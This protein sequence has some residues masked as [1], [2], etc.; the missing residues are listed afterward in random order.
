[1]APKNT[2]L[3]HQQQHQQDIRIWTGNLLFT[4]LQKINKKKFV[5]V[6]RICYQKI[7]DLDFTKFYFLEKY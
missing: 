3:H 4:E 5:N 6:Q 2:P 7:T 1:V